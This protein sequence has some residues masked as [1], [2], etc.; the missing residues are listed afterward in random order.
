MGLLNQTV[1]RAV[2]I[3]DEQNKEVEKKYLQR[4]MQNNGYML[5]NINE[6]IKENRKKNG[7]PNEKY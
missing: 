7:N 3:S 4:I 6:A 2:R 1:T 5:K